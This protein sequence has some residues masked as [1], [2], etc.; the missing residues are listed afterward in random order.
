VFEVLHKRLAVGCECFA[1]PLNAHFSRCGSAFPDVDAPFGSCGSF[2]RCDKGW[3]A[4][5]WSACK[6]GV[7]PSPPSHSA[8]SLCARFRVPLCADTGCSSSMAAT[9]STRPLCPPC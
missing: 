8:V 6:A 7:F 2:F 4:R 5:R 9:R 1:S 3:Q